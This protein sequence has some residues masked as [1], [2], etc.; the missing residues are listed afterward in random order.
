MLST[1]RRTCTSPTPPISPYLS[2]FTGGR[3]DT[4]C[5]LN[6]DLDESALFKIN[7]SKLIDNALYPRLRSICLNDKADTLLVGT[8]G[9]EIYE[10]KAKG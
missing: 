10:L 2:V 9:S 1:A 8:F 4:I 6:S 7:L 3:D 5:V